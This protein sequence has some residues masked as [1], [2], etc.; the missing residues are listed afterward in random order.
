MRSLFAALLLAISFATAAHAADKAWYGFHIKPQTSG[1]VLNPVVQSVM[2]DMIAPNSPADAQHIR[3]GDEIIQAEGKSIR[4]VRAL[5]VI[6]L[7]NKKP[8]DTLE[9]VLQRP[10]GE[11][12]RAKLTAI[13]KPGT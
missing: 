2:I 13:K 3:V 1:F 4:G 12:Y 7:L 6:G 8:G 11:S 5:D 9:L 10:S